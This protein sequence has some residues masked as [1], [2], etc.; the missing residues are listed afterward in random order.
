MTDGIGRVLDIDT[1]S[2]VGLT[3]CGMETAS[4]EGCVESGVTA[5][6]CIR[7]A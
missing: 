2:V 3:K 1:A 7:L 6:R 5:W 4:R